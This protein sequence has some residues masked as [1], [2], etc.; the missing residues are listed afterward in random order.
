M[1]ARRSY[2]VALLGAGAYNVEP[3]CSLEQNETN[4]DRSETD[5]ADRGV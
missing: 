1:G 3:E 2:Q 4:P 5:G